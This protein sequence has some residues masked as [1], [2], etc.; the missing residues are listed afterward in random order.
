M[1][2]VDIGEVVLLV[3]VFVVGVGGFLW[4]ATQED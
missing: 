3:I 1:S 2:D 4:A